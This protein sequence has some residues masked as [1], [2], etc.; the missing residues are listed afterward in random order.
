M[1]K[2]SPTKPV[3]YAGFW[4]RG[5]ALIIDAIVIQIAVSVPVVLIST[6]ISGQAVGFLD[7]KPPIVSFFGFILFIVVTVLFITNY[8]A[9]P[10]KMFYGLKILNSEKKNPTVIQAILR[11]FIG[12]TISAFIL[13]IGYIWAGFDKEKQSLHDKMVGTHVVVTKPISGFKKFTVF[14]I[15][16][17]LFILPILG[18]L[19]AV[20]LVAINPLKKISVARDNQR[21][22]DIGELAASLETYREKNERYP[23]MLSELGSFGVIRYV[24]KDP[25]GG[26]DYYY[27]VK[28]DGSKA[29]LYAKLER[30]RAGKDSVWCWITGMNPY[31]GRAEEVNISN[32]KL[33]N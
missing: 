17:L 13:F 31:P 25:A 2:K 10:G 15:A 29:V 24:P 28:T 21:K 22:N 5:A 1:T 9:T 26:T 14:L 11:E 8:G 12:K 30:G 27:A 6:A 18:I 32:C 3:Q 33:S 7:K 16:F 19:A 23:E 20:G 4:V